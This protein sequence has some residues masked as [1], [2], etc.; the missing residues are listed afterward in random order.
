V[1]SKVGNGWERKGEG[2]FF[3][4][5]NGNGGLMELIKTRMVGSQRCSATERARV[6]R[7]QVTQYESED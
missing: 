6:C 1:V 2:F 3:S 5:M 4:Y 7:S